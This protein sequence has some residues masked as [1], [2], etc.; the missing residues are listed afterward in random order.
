VHSTNSVSVPSELNKHHIGGNLQTCESIV[1]NEV[2]V[3]K[4]SG[5][6]LS[7]CKIYS[8]ASVGLGQEKVAPSVSTSFL[9]ISA[10]HDLN[11]NKAV[12]NRDVHGSCSELS[13]VSINSHLEDSYFTRDS[14]IIL[15]TPNSTTSAFC[16]K[17]MS[18]VKI[19]QPHQPFGKI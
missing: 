6:I 9:E 18:I 10:P 5:I 12:S 15:F 7:N 17:I 11:T 3:M 14:D 1:I 8:A 16:I 19:I 2:T 13:F 4:L